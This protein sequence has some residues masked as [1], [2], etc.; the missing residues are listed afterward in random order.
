MPFFFLNY[1]LSF[2]YLDDVSVLYFADEDMG[3]S[4]ALAASSQATV[5]RAKTGKKVCLKPNA[6]LFARPVVLLLAIFWAILSKRHFFVQLS[7]T[8]LFSF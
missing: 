5:G 3:S 4:E 8:F 1:L 7:T 6:M 2:S